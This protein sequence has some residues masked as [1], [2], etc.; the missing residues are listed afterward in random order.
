[1][2]PVYKRS[3]VSGSQ[4]MGTEPSLRPNKWFDVFRVSKMFSLNPIVV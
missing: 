1:M 4:I 2:G 3:I